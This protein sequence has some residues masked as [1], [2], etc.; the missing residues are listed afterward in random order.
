MTTAITH[1]QFNGS[2]P[3]IVGQRCA[4]LVVQHFYDGFTLRDPANVVFLR[5]QETWYRIYFET[6]TVFWRSGDSP[7]QPVNSTLEHGLL[8]NDLSELSSIVGHDLIEIEYSAT[9][10]GDVSVD[11]RFDGGALLSLRYE[12]DLDVTQISV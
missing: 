9:E 7:E 1:V 5:F 6:G 3:E 11:F 8:L 10:R 12:T 4:S 2:P